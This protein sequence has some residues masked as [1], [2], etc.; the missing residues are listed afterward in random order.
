MAAS[1]AAP[2]LSSIY[3]LG[4]IRSW[5]TQ[6]RMHC[7]FADFSE[8]SQCFFCYADGKGRYKQPVVKDLRLHNAEDI[9]KPE[10][11][12]EMVRTLASAVKSNNPYFRWFDSGDIR[13]PREAQLIL[14]VMIATPHIS[15][16]LPTRS[17]QSEAILPILG[18]MNALPNVVC[19]FTGRLLNK[20]PPIGKY[21]AVVYT[22]PDCV[23]TAAEGCPA[24]DKKS[25]GGQCLECR[26][27]W[28]KSAKL[29]A[30]PLI[31][32][33]AAAAFGT[34]RERMIV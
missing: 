21:R 8:N 1:K 18:E 24:Y 30:Y 12:T 6:A 4:G 11:V 34:V 10:W 16:W 2:K 15:H 7:K 23:P 20:Q 17:W 28:D 25:R 14:K 3:K 33:K 19:R 26:R 29:I 9:F 27:C 32:K 13:S 5:S 31:G 22:N